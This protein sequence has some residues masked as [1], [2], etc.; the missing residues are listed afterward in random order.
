MKIIRIG[1]SWINLDSVFRSSITV[2]A[3]NTERPFIFSGQ[4]SGG[5]GFTMNINA[6][7]ARNIRNAMESNLILCACKDCKYSTRWSNGC[8]TEYVCQ[9]PGYAAAQINLS[10]VAC[11]NFERKDKKE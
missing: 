8:G 9:M 10:D 3:E 4:L 2:D 7:E 6:I 11:S 1:S 5:D